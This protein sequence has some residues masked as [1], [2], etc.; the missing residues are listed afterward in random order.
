MDPATSAVRA[1]QRLRALARANK[2]R[3]ARAQLKRRIASGEVSVAAVILAP[4]PD[5]EGIPVA[6]LLASQPWWGPRRSK[7]LLAPANVPATKPVGAL[8]E[9]QRRTLAAQLS[10]PTMHPREDVL[11]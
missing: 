9:R 2:V 7:R 10:A 8:T 6:E 4:G 5:V 3:H 1:E 11:G